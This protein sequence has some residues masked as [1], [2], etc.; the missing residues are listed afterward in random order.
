MNPNEN[1]YQLLNNNNGN[2]NINE[3]PSP[4]P[5]IEIEP[6][7]Q[8]NPQGEINNNIKSGQ[9]PVEINNNIKPGQPPIEINNNIQQGQTQQ[10]YNQQQPQ[11]IYQPPGQIVYQPV[12]QP[13]YGQN[14]VVAQPQ[15][16]LQGGI[17]IN[18]NQPLFAQQIF[19][20]NPVN[21]ICPFC[22][23]QINTL[24][25]THFNCGA[26]CICCLLGVFYFLMQA[27]RGKDL[28][29]ND[30]THRCPNCNN[31]VGQYQCL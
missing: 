28:M 23:Q 21:M 14:I 29:C 30:A 7:K 31:V 17:V 26:C 3:V 12:A 2:I 25:E 13:L 24:V 22:K 19:L 9:P 18:Q 20:V 1:D 10:I 6:P 5:Q 11:V 15:H 8:P 16:L 4:Y 27:V